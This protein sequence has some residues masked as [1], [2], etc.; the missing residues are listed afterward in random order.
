MDDD[1]IEPHPPQSDA[2]VTAV[3]GP[4]ARVRDALT[5][6]TSTARAWIAARAAAERRE[7][8]EAS[9]ELMNAVARGDVIVVAEDAQTQGREELSDDA[10]SGGP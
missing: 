5:G 7:P 10:E 8:E 1:E 4:G 6:R 3:L 2:P 9:D